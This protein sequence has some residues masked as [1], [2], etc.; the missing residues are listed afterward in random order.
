PSSSSTT[1]KTPRGLERAASTDLNGI[2]DRAT[3]DIINRLQEIGRTQVEGRPA[4]LEPTKR[5]RGDKQKRGPRGAEPISILDTSLC[6]EETN[7]MRYWKTC[8]TG[9]G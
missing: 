1:S 9:G 3:G 4:R 8:F 6:S 5:P 7:S 2:S